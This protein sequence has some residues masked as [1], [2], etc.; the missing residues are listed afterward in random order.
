MSYQNCA[1]Y[2]TNKLKR[3]EYGVLVTCNLKGEVKENH[4]NLDISSLIKTTNI[5][6]PQIQKYD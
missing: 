5:L 3:K 6:Y 1:V 4:T 2:K